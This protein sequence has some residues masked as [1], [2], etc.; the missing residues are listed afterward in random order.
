VRCLTAALASAHHAASDAERVD[1]LRALEELKSAASAAQARLAVAFDVSQRAAQAEAGVPARRLGAGVVEQLALARR[2]SPFRGSSA[3]GMAKALVREMP[4]TLAALES[5]R[6][7][8][9]RAMLLV[10]ETACLSAETRAQVDQQ[11]CGPDAAEEVSELGDRRLVAA[12][13][14]IGYRLEPRS[15]VQR[16]RR[17]E[18]ERC[19]TVRPA[20]DTMAYLTA[21]LPVAQAVACRKALGDAADTARVGGERRSRGQVMAD[22]LVARLTGLDAASQHHPASATGPELT[23]RG[24]GPG[25]ATG[26]AS[27]AAPG[28][29]SVGETPAPKILL[30]LVMTDR[31]LLAGDDEPAHLVGYGTVPAEWAR[32]LL[33]AHPGQLWLRRLL[34]D[35]S[36]VTSFDPRAR[37]F[38]AGLRQTLIAR[39]QSCRTPWC[40]APIRHADHVVPHAAGGPTTLNGGQGLCEACNY[41]KQAPGWAAATTP[42]VAAAGRDGPLGV[43]HTVDTTTPTGHTYRSRAPGPR[44]SSAPGPGRREWA[45]ETEAGPPRAVARDVA[46]SA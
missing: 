24:A 29:P 31:S 14:R 25:M 11:L 22:T 23:P 12:A 7:S 5:G 28:A 32:D 41:A 16:A 13:Q 10:R 38:P 34:T 36:T 42:S 19:V 21:L 9:W 15:V 8:E 4:H 33:Q 45:D 17:A 18:N 1:L 40:D 44:D 26:A 30:S 6:L 46:R 37:L 20:P 2:L 3:L 35:G 27:A 43:P 39:D